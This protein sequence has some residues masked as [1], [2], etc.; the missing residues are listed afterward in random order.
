MR[1]IDNLQEAQLRSKVREAVRK[2][3]LNFLSNFTEISK[4]AKSIGDALAIV[5][6]I[7]TVLTEETAPTLQFQKKKKK[8]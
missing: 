7:G 6:A 1:S 8:K 3:P 2:N 5:R 4:G